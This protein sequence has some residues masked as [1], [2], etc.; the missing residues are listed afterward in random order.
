MADENKQKQESKRPSKMGRETWEDRNGHRI[1]SHWDDSIIE[2]KMEEIQE[3]HWSEGETCS[4]K[5]Q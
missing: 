3:R 5:E 1:N 4:S 2:V